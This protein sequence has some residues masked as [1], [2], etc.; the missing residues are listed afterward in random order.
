MKTGFFLAIFFGLPHS[1]AIA[2]SFDL[3]SLNCGPI[4][5][6]VQNLDFDRLGSNYAEECTQ[7]GVAG[8]DKRMSLSIAFLDSPNADAEILVLGREK[9]NAPGDA[10]EFVLLNKRK[11]EYKFDFAAFDDAVNGWPIYSG[12]MAEMMKD[13]GGLKTDHVFRC[14][15]S[16]EGNYVI[17]EMRYVGKKNGHQWIEGYFMFYLPGVVSINYW[18]PLLSVNSAADMKRYKRMVAVFKSMK[19]PSHSP[20]HEKTTR[21]GGCI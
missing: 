17:S 6:N 19:G 12:R 4:M 3:F 20:E 8:H 7:F 21:Y 14:G 13:E 9:T 1:A 5:F 18:S 2:R 16:D 15:S 10:P 11:N